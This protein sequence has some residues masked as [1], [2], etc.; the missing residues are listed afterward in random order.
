MS[1][2]QEIQRILINQRKIKNT[3]DLFEM[4]KVE[5]LAN[6]HES[7]LSSERSHEQEH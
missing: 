3:N 5:G 6:K 1:D 4:T 2:F 7:E